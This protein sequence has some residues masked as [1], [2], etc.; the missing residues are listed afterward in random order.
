MYTP[1]QLIYPDCNSQAC[2]LSAE[3]IITRHRLLEESA[4]EE[5]VLMPSHFPAPFAAIR[6]TRDKNRYGFSAAE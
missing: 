2:E 4:R 3:G 6:V 1:L 5:H